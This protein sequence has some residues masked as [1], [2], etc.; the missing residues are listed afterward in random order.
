MD[1]RA[2]ASVNYAKA[3]NEGHFVGSAPRCAFARRPSVL[4]HG[5]MLL[6]SPQR[7]GVRRRGEGEG[8][9]CAS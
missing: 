2:A 5:I 8:R 6:G 9:K 4:I 3:H 7:I 1:T